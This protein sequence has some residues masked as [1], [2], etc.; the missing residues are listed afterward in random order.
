MRAGVRDVVATL[1]RI[2]DAIAARWM[3]GFYTQWVRAAAAGGV[4]S[5]VL[6]RTQRAWLREH[7]NAELGHPRHWAGFVWIGSS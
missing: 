4:D 3:S 5:A 6:T 1:W 7:R 2:D